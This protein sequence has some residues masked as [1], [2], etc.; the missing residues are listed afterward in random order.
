MKFGMR[1]LGLHVVLGRLVGLF[2]FTTSQALGDKWDSLQTRETQEMIEESVAL[3]VES[4]RLVV[5]GDQT[6]SDLAKLEA[7]VSLLETSGSLR[8]VF[9][10]CPKDSH[11]LCFM[12]ADFEKSSGQKRPTKNV[13]A[14]QVPFSDTKR[15]FANQEVKKFCND[16][17]DQVRLVLLAQN[18]AKTVIQFAEKLLSMKGCS[19]PEVA[20]YTG[21]KLEE[22]FP[23]AH[24]VQVAMQVYA[25]GLKDLPPEAR[26]SPSGFFLR[27]RLGLLHTWQK[28]YKMAFAVLSDLGQRASPV[29]FEQNEFD[30]DSETLQFDSPVASDI[31]EVISALDSTLLRI[32]FWRHFSAQ[33]LGLVNQAL[34]IKKNIQQAY[35]LSFYS[36]ILNLDHMRYSWLRSRKKLALDLSMAPFSRPLTEGSVEN[37]QAGDFRL[38]TQALQKLMAQKK[39]Q[40]QAVRLLSL[41]AQ[42]D[43]FW[44]QSAALQLGWAA[45]LLRE[46]NHIQAFGILA[47]LIRK[48][49]SVLRSTALLKLLYPYYNLQPSLNL[50]KLDPT[51][52]LS[53]IRQESAFNPAAQSR[54]GAYGLMQLQLPTARLLSRVVK[55]QQLFEPQVNVKLGSGYLKKLLDQFNGRLEVALCAYNAGPHRAQNWI[56]RYPVENPLLFLDLLPVKET[57]EYAASIMRNYVIYKWLYHGE[58]PLV[59]SAQGVFEYCPECNLRLAMGCM[60][61]FLL[62]GRSLTV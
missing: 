23:A 12:A 30:S 27:Y 37:A 21:L 57:R 39:T 2:L 58:F 52:V 8:E 19:A 50:S 61:K 3:L 49:P 20:F 54:A 55:R 1:R 36:L 51:L 11:L 28:D 18:D 42:T 53:V 26:Q 5:K 46:K 32:Q 59:D 47:K 31:P 4:N 16:P 22:W 34:E 41:G 43:A 62:N 17:A 56:Q 45:L 33:K 38:L 6:A 10:R 40:S 24:F 7:V 44:S 9:D 60:R 29:H 15:H 14:V 35:P 25:H 48:K 13:K